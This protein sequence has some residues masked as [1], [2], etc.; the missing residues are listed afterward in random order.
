MNYYHSITEIPGQKASEEQ[1]ARIYHRY[2]FAKEFAKAKDVLEIACGSGIGLGFL[3]GIARS[4]VG[5]D[6][7]RT[8]VKIAS[9]IYKGTSIQIKEMDAHKL[10]FEDKSFDLVL[11]FEAIY[12]LESP[13]DFLKEAA[14]VLR[15]DGRL[16]ICTVNKDW[17]DFHPSQYSNTYFSLPELNNLLNLDFREIHAFGAFPAEMKGFKSY[18]FSR[19]KRTAVRF[20]LIP[21]SLS[22]RAYMKRIF[23]GPLKPLPNQVFEGMVPYEPPT[24][25][26]LEKS[27]TDFK[28]IYLSAVKRKND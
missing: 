25:I 3:A 21:G 26:P 20:S 12:Y 2:R 17:I 6:I 27:T 1:I 16:I 24:S 4:I 19:I 15:S 5:G 13:Q 10:P 11:L 9:G 18:L 28:I 22:A 23:M 8:N 14:R 7:D